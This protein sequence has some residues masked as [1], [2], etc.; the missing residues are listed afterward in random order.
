MAVSGLKLGQI[1]L[2]AR[3]DLF[4]PLSHLGLG[5]VPVPLVDRF[6]LAPVGGHCCGGEQA[7]TP[8]HHDE[9]AARFADGRAVVFAKIGDG[10][11]IRCQAACQPHRLDVAL[12]FPL[13]PA[14]RLNAVETVF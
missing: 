11:E 4:H 10:L 6:E 12:A 9:L 7:R 5:E 3:L 2:D 1:P 8:A 13:K 14:A